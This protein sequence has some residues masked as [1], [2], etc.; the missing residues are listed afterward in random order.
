V[1]FKEQFGRRRVI[2]AV[3]VAAGILL[4]AW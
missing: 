1:F 2:A 4:I 3:I